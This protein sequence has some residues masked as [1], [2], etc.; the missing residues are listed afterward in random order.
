MAVPLRRLLMMAASGTHHIGVWYHFHFP[1]EA[2]KRLSFDLHHPWIPWTGK[3]F[4]LRAVRTLSSVVAPIPFCLHSIPMSRCQW[5]GHLYH[6]SRGLAGYPSY[7]WQAKCSISQLPRE[8]F[9]FLCLYHPQLDLAMAC[10]AEI[11]LSCVLRTP[12]ESRIQIQHGSTYLSHHQYD[13][14]PYPTLLYLDLV[15]F[16][17]IKLISSSM[18]FSN[19]HLGMEFPRR[20]QNGFIAYC[21]P[22]LVLFLFDVLIY[23]SLSFSAGCARTWRWEVCTA[24]PFERVRGGN[25]Y[26]LRHYEKDED[27]LKRLALWYHIEIQITISLKL[28]GCSVTYTNIS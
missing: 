1:S 27:G 17:A 28:H 12:Q 23:L 10:R 24:V 5:L 14:F 26:V 11:L 7:F 20:Q 9:N 4:R 15:F 16:H 22:S 25:R 19:P 18:W 13:I 6:F 21:I 3:Q 8:L 2:F